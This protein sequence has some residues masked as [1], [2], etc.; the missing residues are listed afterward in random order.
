MKKIDITGWKHVFAFTFVQTVKAK[1]YI[2]TLIILCM[3][4]ALSIPVYCFVN[5]GSN[6]ESEGTASADGSHKI[7]VN[8]IY[9]SYDKADLAD[10]FLEKWKKDFDCDME[11][12]EPEKVESVSETL[13]DVEKTCIIKILKEN[14]VYSIDVVTGWDV[15]AIYSDIDMVSNSMAEELHNEQMSSVISGEHM[16]DAGK[17]VVAYTDG[18]VAG[19]DKGGF[20]RY[21]VWLA[22]ITILTFIVTFSGQGI[23]NSIITEKSNKLVEYFMIT[24]RPMAIVIGKVLAMLASLFIQIGAVLL[25]VVLSVTLSGSL[26]NVDVTGKIDII[27]ESMVESNILGGLDPFSICLAIVVILAGLL[28]F[29]FVASI[30]GA[31]VSKL[32]ESAEGMLMFTMLVIVGAYM[33][34]ALSMGNIFTE[35]GELTGVFAYICC[36]LPISSIFTVPANLVMGSIP[37]WLA[38]V[39]LAILIACVVFLV[40]ITSKI[41]EY[42]LFYNGVKL[43]VKDIIHIARYGR[44]KEAE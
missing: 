6:G 39:S 38:I 1:S 18:D 35:S 2:V 8:K 33:S 12:L 3:I 13:N 9:V 17:P 43:G 29:A 42:L 41:Y 28:F 11:Y 36:L 34:I 23:A 16:E 30:A 37:V 20:G 27:V 21:G 32:E 25:S 15:T 7:D 24:I 44:V 40:I 14:N 31:S 19:S 26:I 10:S 5:Y 22:L 4:A